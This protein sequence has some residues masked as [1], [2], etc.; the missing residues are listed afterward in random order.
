MLGANLVLYLAL[1]K[2]SVVRRL[3]QVLPFFSAS[4]L[5]KHLSVTILLPLLL[6]CDFLFLF[7]LLLLFLFLCSSL[8][9]LFSPSMTG[10]LLPWPQPDDDCDDDVI[11]VRIR[12]AMMM[13][14]MILIMMMMTVMT[15]QAGDHS[16]APLLLCWSTQCSLS[17]KGVINLVKPSSS[18]SSSS[19]SSSSPST[20]YS[21]SEVS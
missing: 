10:P 7:F 6:V 15:S 9:L 14:M 3:Q 19:L 16:H 17:F 11:M 18:S 2:V 20:Q 5:F 8:N 13:M 4:V 1:V 21:F 12:M